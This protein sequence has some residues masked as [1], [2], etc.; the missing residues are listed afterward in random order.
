MP[1][2]CM[3]ATAG[4]QIRMVRAFP[5]NVC[6][7]GKP[8]KVHPWLLGSLPFI[9]VTRRASQGQKRVSGQRRPTWKGYSITV[10]LGVGHLSGWGLKFSPPL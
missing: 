10:C 6:S 1:T 2:Q 4:L 3:E 9:C 7:V 5:A 8:P